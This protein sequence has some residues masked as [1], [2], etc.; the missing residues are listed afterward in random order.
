ME[1]YRIKI[2]SWTASFRYPNLISGFQPSLPVPPLSTIFGLFSAALGF[3][4]KPEKLNLGFVFKSKA[5]IIDLET[6]YQVNRSLKNINSNVIKREILFD[7]EL[8]IY[9]EN[10][11]IAKAFEKPYFQI[12][13][14]RSSDLATVREVKRIQ[15]IEKTELN[16][17]RGTVIPFGK[18]FVPAP[19][20]ALPI[21]FTDEIPRRNIGTKPFCLLDSD[22]NQTLPISAFGFLDEELKL[23]V[24]WQE[25]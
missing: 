25:Q 5:K 8:L 15:V 4:Y 7:N 6:I 13:L 1:L 21:Y 10:E 16:K 19:I 17:L 12:L 14:G 11:K 23:E 3:Y 24:F 9:T 2:T 18:F 22:Y 20:Q